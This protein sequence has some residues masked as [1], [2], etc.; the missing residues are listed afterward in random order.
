M[1]DTS[2]QAFLHQEGPGNHQVRRGHP[3]TEGPCR[4]HR[5]RAATHQVTATKYV[6]DFVPALLPMP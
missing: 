6:L 4:L 2:S 5:P 3:R 1:G